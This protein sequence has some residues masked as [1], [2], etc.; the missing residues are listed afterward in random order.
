MLLKRKKVF[1]FSL[2]AVETIDGKVSEDQAIVQR[3]RLSTLAPTYYAKSRSSK[4]TS[5]TKV[6]MVP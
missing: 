2:I 1:I 5:A 6:A 4:K 3:F